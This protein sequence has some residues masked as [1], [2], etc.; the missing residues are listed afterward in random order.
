MLKKTP[1]LNTEDVDTLVDVAGTWS[2]PDTVVRLLDNPVRVVGGEDLDNVLFD[3][4]FILIGEAADIEAWRAH[5]SQAGIASVRSVLS[6]TSMLFLNIYRF[7]PMLAALIPLIWFGLN[8]RVLA[9]LTING[10]NASERARFMVGS[11]ALP[12]IGMLLLL[13]VAV[14]ASMIASGKTQLLGPVVGITGGYA[15]LA[16]LPWVFSQ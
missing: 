2:G 3:G 10:A 11:I 12:V 5:L 15:L 9:L 16:C 1:E 8:S 7:F 4:D 6:E 14:C 13:G